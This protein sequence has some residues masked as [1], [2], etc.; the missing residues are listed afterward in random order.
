MRTL[1]AVTMFTSV[2]AAS[3]A[4]AEQSRSLEKVK[5]GLLPSGGF[6]SVYAAE[7]GDGSPASLASLE[8]GSR[9]CT[10]R[11]EELDCFRQSAD[12]LAQACDRS[13][14]LAAAG[15]RM[16]AVGGQQ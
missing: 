6:Y 8:R 13:E 12:A 2:L 3:A 15:T 7:C 5:S 1:F 16:D 11:G 14:K 9:W 10:S 4:H